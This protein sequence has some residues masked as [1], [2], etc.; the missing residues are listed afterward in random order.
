MAT[1]FQKMVYN[2]SGFN[3]LGLHRDDLLY[4]N[5]DVKEALKRVP[6]DIIDVRNYRILRAVQLTI[7]KDILPKD[8][9]TKIEEDV[10]YLTPIVNQV[11]KERIEQENWNKE[12]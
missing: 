1:A 9:W 8:E 4:E 12:H 3:K 11:E 6:Q 2:L 7:Q 10:L 5:D